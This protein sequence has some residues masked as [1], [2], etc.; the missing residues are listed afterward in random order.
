MGREGQQIRLDG[1]FEKQQEI[2]EKVVSW[3]LKE[4]S[5]CRR[6][7]VYQNGSDGVGEVLGLL[8]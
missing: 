4:A 8:L 1:R 7:A 3:E 6:V 2:Q 5:I